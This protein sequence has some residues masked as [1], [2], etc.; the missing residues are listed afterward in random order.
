MLLPPTDVPPDRLFRTLLAVPRAT[1]AIAFRLDAAPSVAFCV[2]AV[3]SLEIADAVA[4]SECDVPELKALRLPQ[5]LAAAAVKLSNGQHAFDS[6][7]DVGAL[8]DAE[9]R[10]LTK[11]V[12]KALSRISP[13]ISRSDRDAWVKVLVEGASAPGNI[14][15]AM[16][17]GNCVDV[18][19]GF[20]SSVTTPRPDRFFGVPLR[21][22]TDGHWFAW[23]AARKI[24]ERTQ[25]G[26]NG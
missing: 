19:S 10:L 6:P 16:S 14:L 17:L 12:V 18:A 24:V 25:S 15:T 4:W 22:L 1:E 8:E 9:L 3:T 11:A 20:S 13:T 2:S 7:E 21:Q 5:A 26:K 23:M